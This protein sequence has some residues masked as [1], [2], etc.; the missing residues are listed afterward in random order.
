MENETWKPAPYAPYSEYYEVSNLGRLRVSKGRQ[1]TKVGKI[2]KPTM[3]DGTWPQ[4]TLKAPGG[5]AKTI[6]AHRLIAEAFLPNPEGL[7]DIGFIDGDKTNLQVSNLQW[8]TRSDNM[9]QFGHTKRGISNPNG[10]LTD[11]DV[12]T[13]RARAEKEPLTAIAKEYGIT[14]GHCSNI[15]SR[16]ARKHVV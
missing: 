15:V 14:L 3:R 13:I 1:G 16:K 10:R 12:R 9:Q 2:L 8:V 5:H 6:L 4:W 11:D 7:S